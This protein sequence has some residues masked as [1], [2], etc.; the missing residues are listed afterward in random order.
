M[1]PTAPPVTATWRRVRSKAGITISIIEEQK[2]RQ[3]RGDTFREWSP[4]IFEA[5][6]DERL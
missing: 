3:A 4:C 6:R 1:T 5:V 2:G